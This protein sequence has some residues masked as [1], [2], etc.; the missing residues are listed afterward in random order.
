MGASDE[1]TGHIIHLPLKQGGWS[2]PMA[3]GSGETAGRR[4]T[5]ARVVAFLAALL[6]AFAAWLPWLVVTYHFDQQAQSFPV[7][8]GTLAQALPILF[9]DSSRLARPSSDVFIRLMAIIGGVWAG[10][11]GAGVL[12][13]PLLW[14]RPHTR[15]ARIAL[16]LYGLWLL[17][18]T[19]FALALT[20]VIFFPP[21]VLVE[22]A[23]SAP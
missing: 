6:F 20:K 22:R 14:L 17:L 21:A 3:Q 13:A 18:G 10:V 16:M 4:I 23:P 19:I 9:G 5:G 1:K 2:L 11:S 7:D 8:G 15:A 12:L